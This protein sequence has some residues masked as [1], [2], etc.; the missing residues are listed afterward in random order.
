[1]GNRCCICNSGDRVF[2]KL[3]V[4][5]MDA[6]VDSSSWIVRKLLCCREC[7]R[8]WGRLFTVMG[9]VAVGG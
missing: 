4:V 3:R 6:N 1:M 5:T 8:H 7:V 9:T 2:T